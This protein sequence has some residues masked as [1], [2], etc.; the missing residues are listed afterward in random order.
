MKLKIGKIQILLIAA[1]AIFHPQMASAGDPKFSSPEGAVQSLVAAIKSPDTSEALQNMFGKED[2]D[3]WVSGDPAADEAA[4]KRFLQRISEKQ[5]IVAIRDDRSILY[6][7]N[8]GWSFPI[9]L[10]KTGKDWSFD[11][12][13]GREE[14]LNRRIG[15][16][17]ND[18]IE[19]AKDYVRAQKEYAQK[20]R[21]GDGIPGYAQKFVSDPGQKNG[22]YW[23]SQDPQDAS[24]VGPGIMEKATQVSGKNGENLLLYHGYYFRM[25][26]TKEK[27]TTKEPVLIGYPAT[28]G[29]SGVMSFLVNP[30]GT[31]LQKDLG[32][33]TEKLA[34]N[35]QDWAQDKSWKTV[36]S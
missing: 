9:P 1:A 11:L 26:P 33:D 21:D 7:G 12:K 15:A 23:P 22:L 5:N 8:D 30:E 16:N 31:I 6:A 4:K 35:P 24:P 27:G 28:W 14:I 3:L 18:A 17:E 2:K 20:D 10:V 19:A 29:N 25:L 13:T 32:K 34:A 36:G